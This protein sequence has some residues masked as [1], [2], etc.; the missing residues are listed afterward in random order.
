MSHIG[1]HIY[2]PQLVVLK[3]KSVVVCYRG[4]VY[5]KYVHAHLKKTQKFNMYTSNS[6]QINQF[7][8]KKIFLTKFHF[9][10]F[11]KWPKIN[12]PTRKKFKTAKNAISRK[13]FFALFDFTSFLPGLF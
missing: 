1:K 7:H 6:N 5:A 3:Y 2:K 11:R 9:S 13:I 10:Q 12:F 8:E 4:S